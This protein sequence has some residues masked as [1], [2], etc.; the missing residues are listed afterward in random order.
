[1]WTL[2]SSLSSQFQVAGRQLYR[3][4]RRLIHAF[5]SEESYDQIT[6]EEA[7]AW[8]L[9]AIYELTSEEYHRGMTSAGRAFR[10]I[11][12]MRLY[13]IDAPQSPPVSQVQDQDQWQL[14]LAGS[15]QEDWIDLETKRRTFWLAF[16]IDRFTSMIDGLQMSFDERMVSL[17]QMIFRANPNVFIFRQIRTKLPAPEA[18]FTSG[19]PVNMGFLTDIIRVVDREWPDNDLSSFSG[20]VIV[21]TICGQVL[22]HKQRCPAVGPDTTDTTYD[23]CHRHRSLS[24]MSAQ[25]LEMLRIHASLEHM[26]PIFAFTAL[27][28]YTAVFMLYDIIQS[29]PLGTKAQASQ[30]IKTLHAEHQQQSIEAVTDTA[31]V[32]VTLGQHFQVRLASVTSDNRQAHHPIKGIMMGLASQ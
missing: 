12:M 5:E 20:T 8:V 24:A 14:N 19:R 18:N 31:L 9:L 2:A 32:V 13:E 23:F 3:E 16:T 11:Q 17:S 6:I 4:T 7:Q 28:A 22:E 21:A 25:Y 10:L 26:D 29:N 1:M 15:I 30:L 27:A